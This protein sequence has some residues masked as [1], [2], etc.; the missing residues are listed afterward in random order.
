M[1]V[2]F[3]L[4]IVDALNDRIGFNTVTQSLCPMPNRDWQNRIEAC[5]VK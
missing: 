1:I 4:T 2:S 5:R 3:C